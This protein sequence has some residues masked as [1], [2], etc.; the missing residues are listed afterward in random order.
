MSKTENKLPITFEEALRAATSSA[1]AE[2]LKGKNI[3]K[4]STSGNIG[5][6][7]DEG[8]E[9]EL[10]RSIFTKTAELVNQHNGSDDVFCT[11]QWDFPEK[12]HFSQIAQIIIE[13][14][15][16]TLLTEDDI[17]DYDEHPECPEPSVIVWKDNSTQVLYEEEEVFRN[18]AMRYDYTMTDEEFKNCMSVLESM[19][20]CK[21]ASIATKGNLIYDSDTF[22]FQTEAK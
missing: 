21:E 17:G 10:K 1:I 8:F 12:L 19:F 16:I 2:M 20:Y 22:K 11:G 6:Y 13:M 4:R 3:T 9:E 14:Y 15:D 18:I 5:E 7:F